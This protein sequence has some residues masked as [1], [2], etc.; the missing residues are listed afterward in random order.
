MAH[1]SIHLHHIATG[2]ANGVQISVGTVIGHVG[3]TGTASNGVTHVHHSIYPGLPGPNDRY[4]EGVTPY[5]HLIAVEQ[6]LCN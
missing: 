3:Y 5:S 4:D 6:S 2:I 1:R